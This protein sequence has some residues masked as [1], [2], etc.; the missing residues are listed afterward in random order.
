M[1]SRDDGRTWS[2]AHAATDTRIRAMSF[3]DDTL[4]WAVTAGGSVLKSM[5]GGSTWTDP[6][7]YKR[8]PAPWYWLSF[9]LVGALLMPMVRRPRPPPPI[10]SVADLFVSDR[11]IRRGDPDALDLSSVALG[12]SR[13][14]RNTKTEPPLTIAVTGQW[15]T[16]KSSL[17]NLLHDDLRG[18]GF[19]PIWFNAW[20]HQKEEHLLASLLQRVQT[21]AVPPLFHRNGLGFRFRLLWYRAARFRW[22]AAIVVALLVASLGYLSSDWSQ[23]PGR[24]RDAAKG[25]VTGITG[26]FKDDSVTTV[27]SKSTQAPAVQSR[28]SVVG[29]RKKADAGPEE[30][31]SLLA[32]LGVLASIVTTGL[33]G[34]RAFGAVP[35]ALMTTVRGAFKLKDLKAQTGF[36]SQFETEFAEVTRALG[37]AQ[38]VILIDDLDRCKPE[39]VLEVLE[40][41]N[42]LCSSG[43]CFVVLA[44]DRDFVEGCVG[45]GFKHVAEELAEFNEPPKAVNEPT[46]PVDAKAAAQAESAARGRQIRRDFAAQYLEKLINLE[47]PVPPASATQLGKIIARPAEIGALLDRQRLRRRR[48]SLAG[49]GALV[50]LAAAA[51]VSLFQL[52]QHKGRRDLAAMSAARAPAV[53]TPDPLP[54][55]PPAD[56]TGPRADL[57]ISPPGDLVPAE[58]AP[59]SMV[60]LSISVVLLAAAGIVA[61]L[62]QPA[63]TVQDRKEFTEAL[64]V[65][66]PFLYSKRKTPRA[67]KRFVNRVRL[68]AMRQQAHHPAE[69]LW[70]R[71]CGWVSRWHWLSGAVRWVRTDDIAEKLRRA[72]QDGDGQTPKPAPDGRAIPEDVLVALSSIR[73]CRADWLQKPELYSDFPVFLETV[74]ETEPLPESVQREL[75]DFRR[76]GSLTPYREKFLRL[77]DSVRAR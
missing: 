48:M 1:E 35:A 9:L 17:M 22:A 33:K 55:A 11:P 62:R 37:D 19:R 15:G 54:Q 3:T 71:L 40:A 66:S 27:S 67:I 70:D 20:H 50:S 43:A 36:R 52:S 13:F 10:E 65:W 23:Q 4:G 63:V 41:I 5:D 7:R 6:A 59:R 16:G 32:V 56:P 14:I 72:E 34:L 30:A 39:N 12:L 69:T 25:I 76:W 46:K 28:D 73:E 18:Y 57:Q 45:I 47:V 64:N 31:L 51:L 38:M 61:I 75:A 24:I 44:M 21:Q 49:R 2:L 60:L 26:I 77:S 8:A 42:F 74:D 58:P 53:R 68:Y 29:P